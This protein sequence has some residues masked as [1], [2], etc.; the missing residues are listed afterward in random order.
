MNEKNLA[1]FQVV[2][3][4][5]AQFKSF[6]DAINGYEPFRL[7]VESVATKDIS[8]IGDSVVQLCLGTTTYPITDWGI[9]SLCKLFGIPNPFARKIPFDLLQH[10]IQRLTQT[11]SKTPEINISLDSDGHVVGVTPF[12]YRPL[13]T[14]DILKNLAETFKTASEIDIKLTSHNLFMYA[15]RNLVKDLEPVTGDFTK[16]GTVITNSE[17]GDLDAH[18]NLYLLRLICTNGAVVGDKWGRVVRNKNNTLSYEKVLEQF[19]RGCGILAGNQASLE[20]CY[21]QLPQISLNSSQ[22]VRTQRT[23]HTVLRDKDEVNR[24]LKTDPEEIKSFF[25]HERMRGNP[26]SL[27]Y[28]SAPIDTKKNAYEVFNNMTE[29]ARDLPNWR[30]GFILQ[31]LSGK[32]LWTLAQDMKVLNN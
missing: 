17:V 27:Q 30:H 13:Q 19:I 8:L 11:Y 9:K 15:L 21:N 29:S 22:F 7:T 18:A 2:G 25:I 6:N 14:Y 26:D 32:Y 28:G 31:K 4:K 24:I 3:E 23:L 1:D 16:V 5:T 20:Q 10:N 12:A